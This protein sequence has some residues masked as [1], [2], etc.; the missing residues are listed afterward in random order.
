VHQ[1]GET[2]QLETYWK[3][4]VMEMQTLKLLEMR[5]VA[6]TLA[7]TFQLVQICLHQ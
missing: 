3:A 6:M 7:E 4:V 2:L 5:K 1:V